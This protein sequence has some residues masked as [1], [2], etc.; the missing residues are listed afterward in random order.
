MN[1]NEA[2]R[3]EKDVLVQREELHQG[4]FC[5]HHFL[6][7]VL[8]DS[9]VIR[10]KKRKCRYQSNV[11]CQHCSPCNSLYLHIHHIHQHKTQHNICHILNDCH[12]HGCLRILHAHKPTCQDKKWQSGRSAPYTYI[13]IGTGKC[14]HFS[15]RADDRQGSIP[16]GCLQTQHHARNHDGNQ[17]RPLHH[18]HHLCHISR[19]QR[20]CR[21]ATRTHAQKSK[22]PVND[23][24][25]HAAHRY[26]TDVGSRTEVACDGH[27]H[28][29]QQRHRDVRHDARQGEV[30]NLFVTNIHI[31]K[32][33]VPEGYEV[34]YPSGTA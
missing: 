34:V 14:H 27:I 7:V 25:Q 33:N 2:A 3:P 1:Q 21:H 20:L 11:L 16:D 5:K 6:S 15:R 18:S 32:R 17:Q 22:H 8:F 19:P 13:K 30:K 10:Y 26:G 28:Q 23:V 24:E 29:T 12:Q 31:Y 9:Q 4:R